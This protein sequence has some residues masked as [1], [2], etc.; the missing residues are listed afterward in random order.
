MDKR[1]L[2]KTLPYPLALIS[3]EV[4]TLSIDI[5]CARGVQSQ[6]QTTFPVALRLHLAHLAD[7]PNPK[8]TLEP[9]RMRAIYL[10]N[11]VP[12]AFSLAWE[13]PRERPWERD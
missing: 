1:L 2:K 7:S 3:A 12:R 6:S 5:H 9:L 13:K 11:L 10:I 8:N 4:P